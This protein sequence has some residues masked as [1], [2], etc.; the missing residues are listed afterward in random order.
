MLSLVLVIS[1]GI[2]LAANLPATVSTAPSFVLIGAA[3]A[4]LLADAVLLSRIRPFAWHRFFQVAGW[5][6]LAYAVIGGMLELVFALDGTRGA[7]LAILTPSLLVFAVNVPMNLAF[8]VARH[9][10]S[11]S[12]G[13]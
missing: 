11:E 5:A 8:T 13:Y 6:L 9:D 2:Y 10:R 7:A 4:L 1:G 3:G 12:S